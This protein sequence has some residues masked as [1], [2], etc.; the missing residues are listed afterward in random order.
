MRR[1][2]PRCKSKWRRPSFLI[3]GQSDR[4][5]Q[6]AGDCHRPARLRRRLRTRAQASQQG[7]ATIAAQAASEPGRPK[8]HC[9]TKPGA[10]SNDRG[11]AVSMSI[12]RRTSHGFRESSIRQRAQNPRDRQFGHGPCRPACGN[13]TRAQVRRGTAMPAFASDCYRRLAQMAQKAA[14][15]SHTI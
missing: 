3:F 12:P 8:T 5:G 13:R 11:T 14:R 6:K 9:A 2:R 4:S 1:R 7:G 10:G 15:V